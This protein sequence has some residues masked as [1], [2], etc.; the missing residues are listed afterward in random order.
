MRDSSNQ[1]F[2]CAGRPWKRLGAEGGKAMAEALKTNTTLHTLDLQGECGAGRE[3]LAAGAGHKVDRG[4]AWAGGRGW[5]GL[6]YVG[7]VVVYGVAAG[8]GAWGEGPE[9]GSGWGKA[10]AGGARARGRAEGRG[11]SRR[12]TGLSVRRAALPGCEGRVAEAGGG[13][14]LCAQRTASGPSALVWL[15]GGTR[16]AAATAAAPPAT[17]RKVGREA[18]LGIS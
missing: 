16:I 1:F 15:T 2:D 8:Q 4:A 3:D 17:G 14:A 13:L 11:R 10:K 12:C 5:G 7:G 6:R 18:P 9:S